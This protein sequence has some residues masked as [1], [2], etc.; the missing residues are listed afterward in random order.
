MD[1]SSVS[2][3]HWS[4]ERCLEGLLIFIYVE[5][6]KILVLILVRKRLSSRVDD[7]LG[8][9][10]KAGKKEFPSSVS[11]YFGATEDFG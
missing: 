4:P 2:F 11:F 3:W 1:I 10:S 8:T 5:I 6:P 7:S 9:M